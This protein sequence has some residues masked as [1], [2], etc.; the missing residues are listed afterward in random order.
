AAEVEAHGGVVQPQVLSRAARRTAPVDLGVAV[1][2]PDAVEPLEGPYLHDDRT[3]GE[4][5][6]GRVDRAQ[7]QRVEHHAARRGGGGPPPPP[8]RPSV[9]A[10]PPPPQD[11]P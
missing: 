7:R 3:F 10:D 1:P 8:P 9:P 11:A 6:S 2:G 5:R 4:R